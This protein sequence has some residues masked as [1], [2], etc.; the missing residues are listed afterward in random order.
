LRKRAV[1]NCCLELETKRRVGRPPPRRPG[2]RRPR[3]VHRQQNHVND[4]A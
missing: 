1:N 4:G 3:I 2:A